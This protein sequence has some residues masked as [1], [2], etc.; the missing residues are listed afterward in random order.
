MVQTT[1]QGNLDGF[2]DYSAT[3]F[4]FAFGNDLLD[5][6]MINKTKKTIDK[7]APIPCKTEFAISSLTEKN[8]ITFILK[9][10]LKI[11]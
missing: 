10:S 3:E 1:V 5:I 8:L 2:V 4:G 11:N 7:I 6:L 9:T